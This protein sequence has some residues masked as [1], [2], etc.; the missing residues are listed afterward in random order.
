MNFETKPLIEI[1]SSFESLHAAFYSCSRGKR[2]KAGYQHFLFAHG[3]KLKAIERELSAT[4]NFRWSGYREFYVHDPKRRLVMAAPFRDRIVHTAI[5]RAIFPQM[6]A[7]LGARTFACRYEMGNRAAVLRLFRQLKAMGKNRYCIK[8]DVRKYF[9]S[10]P[11]DRFLERFLPCLPDRSLD[12]LI[13]SLLASHPRYRERRRGIPIGNLTSQLFANFYLSSMDR[14]ACDHLGISFEEDVREP[15]AH[16]LRYMDDMV[17]LST[18]KKRAFETAM[19]LVHHATDNLGLGIPPE[20]R[21]V[22][23]ND[24]IPF[25]GFVLEE[26]G[27][28]PLRRNERKFMNKL[29]RSVRKGEPLSVRAQRIQSY[30][31]GIR[32][33]AV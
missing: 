28:R 23:A 27:Y 13:R 5:H 11:H 22:L 16:Y 20:K 24:P 2:S 14:L 26:E 19:A 32:L 31:A 1:V 30:E 17:I 8:L 12:P 33:P 3:E 25:L 9:E 10:I 29:K 6:D 18:D 4:R 21:V 7:L 15:H